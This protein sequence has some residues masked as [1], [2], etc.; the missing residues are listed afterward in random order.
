[1]DSK[2]KQVILDSLNYVLWAT[3]METLLKGKDLWQ[4][5]KVSIPDSSNDQAKFV[6][7]RKKDEVAGVITT[8][9]SREMQF[10]TSGIDCPHEV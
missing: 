2:I 5:M 6:I 1:M 8:Y 9:I 10:H 4:Y 7:D 3:D